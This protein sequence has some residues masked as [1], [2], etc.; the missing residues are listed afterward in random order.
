[1]DSFVSELGKGA[2]KGERNK[3][4]HPREG[5]A[6]A[7]G[8][9]GVW[10]SLILPPGF[11]T[12]LGMDKQHTFGTSFFLLLSLFSRCLHVFFLSEIMNSIIIIFKIL[13]YQVHGHLHTHD[14]TRGKKTRLEVHELFSPLRKTRKTSRLD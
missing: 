6:N 7:N 1:M 5:T 14:K 11:S 4:C 9:T 12:N 8:E 13:I 10:I 3:E 2:Q